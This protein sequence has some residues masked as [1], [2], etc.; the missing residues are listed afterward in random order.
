M[1]IHLKLALRTLRQERFYAAI[2]ITGLMI[3]FICTL[4]IGLYVFQSLTYDQHT[5]S[6][7]KLYRATIDLINGDS[8]NTFALMSD[9]M[10]PTLA[11][12]NPDIEGYVRFKTLPEKQI[13]SIG[14]E[15][16]F[17]DAIF[18]SDSNVFQQFGHQSV[19]GDPST[20]LTSPTSIA[21]S[22]SFNQRH[23]SG[24]NSL[25]SIITV[26][27][28]DYQVTLVFSDVPGNSHLKYNLLIPINSPGFIP[29]PANP[30][31]ALFTVNTYTY[32]ILPETYDVQK[33]SDFFDQFWE[34]TTAEVLGDSGISSSMALTPVA[35]VH[36]GPTVEFDQPTGN[37]LTVYA[38]GI[39]GVL[40]MLVAIVNYINLATA[41]ATRRFKE[42]AISRLLGAKKRSLIMQFL[43]ESIMQALIAAI[44]ALIIIEIIFQANAPASLV[45]AL[46]LTSLRT[47]LAITGILFFAGILG[48]LAGLYPASWIS[49]QKFSS[50]TV[51]SGH[52]RT[53]PI[54]RQVLIVFQ[55]AVTIS[56]I[57][58]TILVL[59]QMYFISNMPLGFET[60]NRMVIT[61]KGASAI[62]RVPALKNSMNSL[63][64]IEST[65]FTNFDPGVGFSAGNWRI[66]SAQSQME[67]S[68]MSYQNAD[69][70]YLQSMGLELIEGRFMSPDDENRTVVVNETLVRTM[71][72]TNPIGKRSGMPGSPETQDSEI[73]VGVVKDF[74]FDSLEVPINPLI[75]RLTRPEYYQSLPDSVAPHQIARL[76]IVLSGPA[77]GQLIQQLSST[78]QEHM[79][80]LPF[81]F[82]F[83]DD[84]VASRYTSETGIFNSLSYFSGISVFISCIG[85]LGLTA[86]TTE[87]RTREIGIRKVLGAHPRQLLG[88]LFRNIFVLIL[89]AAIIASVVSYLSINAWLSGFAYRDEINLLV[90]PAAAILTFCLALLTMTLQAWKPIHRNPVHA[91]RYE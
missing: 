25:G 85:L 45:N 87:R 5:E 55:F 2:N 84:I 82:R 44:L 16:H 69:A 64:Q 30:V 37:L 62:S 79:P 71:G 1:L 56:V 21:I 26:N 10:A 4:L 70:D 39:I 66:E 88:M 73:V 89:F 34:E 22:D 11:L 46:D 48:V 41:R 32:F 3:A 91:L 24:E 40:I 86:Y 31:M 68:F 76:T 74:N 49:R 7:K 14:E 47:P 38:Y 75:I 23:F 13:V 83:L 33:F 29:S 77:S 6:H 60:E 90:F 65:T 8:H 61:V 27:D 51:T 52:N 17:E 81:E 42:V 80:E 63:P 35:D 36:F 28:I 15:K 72:W 67:N 59:S 43:Y 20:A 58:S 18:G 50:R 57:A 53:E 9:A 78:W 19:Y 12:Q 54:L